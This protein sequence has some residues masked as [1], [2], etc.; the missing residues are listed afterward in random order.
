[1]IALVVGFVSRMVM[2]GTEG[3]L[4]LVLV[5]CYISLIPTIYPL[6]YQYVFP[7]LVNWPNFLEHQQAYPWFHHLD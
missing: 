1:M 6:I 3:F 5:W 2:V 7:Y 4:S